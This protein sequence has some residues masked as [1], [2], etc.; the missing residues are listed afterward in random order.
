MAARIM[1][2]SPVIFGFDGG[3]AFAPN[4]SGPFDASGCSMG[5][6]GNFCATQ[7]SSTSAADASRYRNELGI[8]I[9]YRNAF[10]PVGLAVSGIY[11]VSGKVDPAGAI[12]ATPAD[13]YQGFS[14]GDIGAEVSFNHQLAIG[15]NVMFGDFNG[16]WGLNPKGSATNCA[17][18]GV[19]QTQ[20][21][22]AIGWTA[23]VK[24]TIP[25][26]PITLGTYYFN[27]KNQGQVGLPTQRVYQGLDVG[28][29]YGLGPGAVL[30]AEYA[31]GQNYQ[32]DYN[33]LQSAV[34][35]ANNKVQAQ[36]FTVG[37]SVRF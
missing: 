22:T 18:A 5:Y 26:A 20:T 14:I 4:N 31:W 13:Q 16:N 10:G 27:Y 7:A 24:Y 2:V 8:G 32:G 19:C 6:G 3:I 23:G 1:Y 12:A 15:A 34:G 9:R 35:A 28:A 36:V 29:V 25:Q 11:T 17:A 33:F 21:T 37:M 30:V